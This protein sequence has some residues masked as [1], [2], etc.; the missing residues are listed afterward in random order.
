MVFH[1]W[2]GSTRP[3]TSFLLQAYADV[4]AHCRHF[5]MVLDVDVVL[6]HNVLLPGL[7]MAYEFMH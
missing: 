7:S 1:N 3:V 4:A 6:V 2:G 5:L